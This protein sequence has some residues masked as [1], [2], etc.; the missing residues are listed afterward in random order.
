M[1][2]EYRLTPDD[3]REAARPAL[4]D[5]Q[6]DRRSRGPTAILGW[7]VFVLLAS[8]L[9]FMLTPD[10]S[11]TANAAAGAGPRPPSQNLWVTLTPALVPAGI[12]VL[13]AVLTAV[14]QWLRDRRAMAAA[15]AG[16]PLPPPPKP[17]G[18]LGL[19][20]MSPLAFLLVCN[21]PA[22]A[23]PWSPTPG[24]AIWVGL[25]PWLGALAVI[26]LVSRWTNRRAPERQWAA[27]PGLNRRLTADL[28]DAGVW[29]TD[30]LTDTLHR[31]PVITRY[32]ETPGLIVLTL[33]DARVIPLP[34][35]ALPDAA[36]DDQLRGLIHTHVASGTFLPR[37]AAFPVLVTAARP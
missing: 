36:A 22:L 24:M 13:A 20:A 31:W 9:T 3:L 35:R 10:P 19:A 7:V 14:H 32:R 33:E 6:P 26:A 25:L 29:A 8:L 1:R 12:L 21:V 30:G 18:L 16:R 11:P 4:P 2:L 34:K 37:E 5:G 15:A 17:S 23:I 28:S 27:D